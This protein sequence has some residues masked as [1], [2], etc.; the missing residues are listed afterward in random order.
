MGAFCGAEASRSAGAPSLARDRVQVVRVDLGNEQR[1]SRFHAVVPRVADNDVAG[2]GESGLDVSRDRRIETREDQLRRTPRR[3]GL[4]GPPGD[5]VRQLAGKTP[6]RGIAK[7]LA[8]RALA[9]AEPVHLEPRMA[10]EQRDEL[11]ADHA[12]RPEDSDGNR[13]HLFCPKKKPTR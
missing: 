4:H 12:G 10:R 9:R 7:R 8:L 2:P 13:R 1:D 3:R 6:C 5:L 11:L